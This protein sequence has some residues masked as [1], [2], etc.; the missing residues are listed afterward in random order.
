[1]V[2][3][4]WQNPFVHRV[5]ESTETV[6]DQGPRNT[7]ADVLFGLPHQ[8]DEQKENEHGEEESVTDQ[9]RTNHYHLRLR[10][11]RPGTSIHPIFLPTGPTAPLHPDVPQDLLRFRQALQ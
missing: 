11:R 6:Q 9:R 2:P 8:Q 7:H 1:M 10:G 3:K 5:I 4:G